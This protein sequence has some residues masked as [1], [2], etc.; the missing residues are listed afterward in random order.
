MQNDLTEHH[1][2]HRTKSTNT[3]SD[4]GPNEPIKKM[5]RICIIVV[6][7]AYALA[8]P[9]NCAGEASGNAVLD[10]SSLAF[11]PV[12]C[13]KGQICIITCKKGKNCKDQFVKYDLRASANLITPGFTDP[14][15][16]QPSSLQQLAYNQVC[17]QK[18]YKPIVGKGDYW[19]KVAK[20][21]RNASKRRHISSGLAECVNRYIR[22]FN[23]MELE[24]KEVTNWQQKVIDRLDK[25]NPSSNCPGMKSAGQLSLFAELR[26]KVSQTY[27]DIYKLPDNTETSRFC[28][29]KYF[30][31]FL[32]NRDNKKMYK[33]S[34]SAAWNEI[35]SNVANMMKSSKP[36]CRKN[37]KLSKAAMSGFK[38]TK[39]KAN[40]VTKNT[41]G[42]LLR[43]LKIDINRLAR[44]KRAREKSEKRAKK[45]ADK[46]AKRARKVAN[47]ASKNRKHKQHQGK[48]KNGRN[49]P[50][51]TRHKTRGGK[52]GA[53]KTKKPA[54]KVCIHA[55]YQTVCITNGRITI[56]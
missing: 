28:Q 19:N 1:A 42:R 6:L 50:T 16:K 49:I 31:N 17:V 8:A 32:R 4:T 34:E 2:S 14:V 22:Y 26:G 24:C 27:I 21:F 30:R 9:A 48:N 10:A 3:K 33:T 29:C 35:S 11:D 7:L 52:S 43:Q 5:F 12:D 56:K 53:E 23:A 13:N 20:L 55:G 45:I 47:K 18:A 54:K 25:F 40:K 36:N 38:E 51:A 41:R 44:S 37:C 15:T 39:K 46:K